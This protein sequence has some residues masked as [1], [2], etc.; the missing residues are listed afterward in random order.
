MQSNA[1]VAG[2]SCYRVCVPNVDVFCTGRGVVLVRVATTLQ[3]FWDSSIWWKIYLVGYTS[4]SRG[5]QKELG[6]QWHCS[7]LMNRPV[8]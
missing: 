2:H 8:Q 6:S 3:A 5:S 7:V 1:K 4:L